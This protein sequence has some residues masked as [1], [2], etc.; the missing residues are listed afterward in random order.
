M[1]LA[2]VALTSFVL[3][4]ADWPGERARRLIELLGPSHVI[5]RR[6]GPPE[7]HYLLTSDPVMSHSCRPRNRFR[8]IKCF[9][10]RR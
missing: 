2:K 9:G 7:E 4:D 1:E 5:I 6:S 3:I 8:S 10:C